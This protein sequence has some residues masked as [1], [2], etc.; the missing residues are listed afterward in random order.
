[1]FFDERPA[2]EYPIRVCIHIGSDFRNLNRQRP[3]IQAN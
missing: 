2:F 3:A 1:V